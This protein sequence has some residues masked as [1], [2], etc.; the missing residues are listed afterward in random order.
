MQLAIKHG[1][2]I[3]RSEDPL[4]T[5]LQI[6]G[7]AGISEALS[8]FTGSQCAGLL[9]VVVTSLAPQASIPLLLKKISDDIEYLKRSMDIVRDNPQVKHFNMRL[10]TETAFSQSSWQSNC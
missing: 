4:T 5:A 7:K 1:A 6:I 3:A 10:F 9:G 2:A 8:S